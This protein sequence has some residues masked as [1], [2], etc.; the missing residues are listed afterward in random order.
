M[1]VGLLFVAPIIILSSE[2]VSTYF[3]APIRFAQ[4]GTGL[5]LG[6]ETVDGRVQQ[7][8]KLPAEAAVE[9]LGY[10][11]FGRGLLFH[12]PEVPKIHST[13]SSVLTGFGFI[14]IL[15]FLPAS[16]R[17][18]RIMYSHR[19]RNA[20]PWAWRAGVGLIASAVVHGLF[21]GFFGGFLTFAAW[22]YF[23]WLAVGVGLLMRS[24]DAAFSNEIPANQSLAMTS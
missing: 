20:D 19:G 11:A 23:F 4:Y 17:L 7:G 6:S 21:D 1:I 9:D 13:F 10:A 16:A 3:R 15:V 18:V 8:F 5:G 14:G 22:T 12:T 2:G 24:W